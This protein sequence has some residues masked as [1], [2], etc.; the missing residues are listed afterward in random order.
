[1]SR[2]FA[3]TN[4]LRTEGTRNLLY[5]AELA[6]AKHIITEGFAGIYEPNK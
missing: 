5:A 1:M 2:D 3:Q 4:P 6:G